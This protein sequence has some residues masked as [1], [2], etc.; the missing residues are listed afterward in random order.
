MVWTAIFLAASLIVVTPS[1]CF[2]LWKIALVSN[3][4]AKEMGIE[5]RSERAG[6]N[7]PQIELEFK[8][9]GEFQTFADGEDK[10]RVELRFGE[11][12]N[13]P[14]TVPLREDRSKPG[15]IEVGFTADRGQLGKLSLWVMAPALDGG[16]AYVLRVDDFVDQTRKPKDMTDLEFEFH[17]GKVSPTDLKVDLVPGKNVVR[18]RRG[19]V[20]PLTIANASSEAIRTTL[21]H[22]WHGGEWP[23]TSLFASVTPIAAKESR[24]FAPVY[25]AGED[26]AAPR[27][28]SLAAD[29]STDIQLRVDWPGTGSVKGDPFI[30]KPG[31]YTVRFALVFETGG[32]RQYA[33]SAPLEVEYKSE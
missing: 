28:F 31:K 22:E 18:E 29:K 16:T 33:A 10:S 9:K 15:R 26:Q 3:E 2:A 23:P 21:A 13:P 25:L 8:T 20:L 30:Q 12:D 11:G 14:V 24:P 7:H 17:R 19:L 27:A 4:Q 32:K 5:I 6:P 1:S